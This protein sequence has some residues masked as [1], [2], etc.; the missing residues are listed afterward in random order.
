MS[1][2]LKMA[3]ENAMAS[4]LVDMEVH[5]RFQ[6]VQV[7]VFASI[8]DGIEATVVMALNSRG[9]DEE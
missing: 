2:L 1:S 5:Q 9:N 6:Q 7:Q 3:T 4:Q 8:R